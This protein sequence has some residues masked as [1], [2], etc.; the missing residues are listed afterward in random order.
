MSTTT[1]LNIVTSIQAYQK[2]CNADNYMDSSTTLEMLNSI[3]DELSN[4]LQEG[5]RNVKPIE[6][7]GLAWCIAY[8]DG[9]RLQLDWYQSGANARGAVLKRQALDME[10]SEF[11]QAIDECEDFVRDAEPGDT[12]SPG[13]G[14]QFIARLYLGAEVGDMLLDT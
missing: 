14:V 1:I 5:A 8:Y 10:P 4:M 9:G 11:V 3:Q 13:W 12:F 2:R 7:Q 6:R